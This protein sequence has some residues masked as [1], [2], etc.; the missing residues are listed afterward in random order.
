[1][2]ADRCAMFAFVL[3]PRSGTTRAASTRCGV[4]VTTCA[5]ES[6]PTLS[7]Y[8]NRYRASASINC[9]DILVTVMTQGYVG[10]ARRCDADV[11]RPVGCR[12]HGHVMRPA[13]TRVRGRRA[14]LGAAV[15]S[16]RRSMSEWHLRAGA[17]PAF[18]AVGGCCSAGRTRAARPRDGAVRSIGGGEAFP[19][20]RVGE[21]FRQLP[22]AHGCSSGPATVPD[23]GAAEDRVEQPWSIWLSRRGSNE[24]RVGCCESVV[25]PVVAADRSS[26][27]RR[28]SRANGCG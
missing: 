22:F 2:T 15:G 5:A 28:G 3:R 17:D 26:G 19:A 7:R 10:D 4:T 20:Q 18:G 13:R 16:L 27:G 6:A 21:P 24:A 25:G 1:M 11:V 14:G 9:A 12:E 8:A 23:V